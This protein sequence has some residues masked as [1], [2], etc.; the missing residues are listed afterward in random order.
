MSVINPKLKKL[1]MRKL[2]DDLSTKEIIPNGRTLWILDSEKQDWF[3]N[4]TCNG[5]MEFN[6]SLSKQYS[7]LFSIENRVFSKILI[8]WFEKK[9]EV[10]INNSQRRTPNLQYLVEVVLNSKNG[11]WDLSERYGFSYDFVKKFLSIEKLNKR[12]LVEDFFISL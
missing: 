1:I 12:V 6:S 7:D 8:E 5:V 3:I 4:V 10:R 11:K 9:F 2:E